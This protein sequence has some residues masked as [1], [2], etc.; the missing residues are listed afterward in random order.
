MAKRSGSN[1]RLEV[2]DRQ[3]TGPKEGGEGVYLRLLVDREGRYSFDLRYFG[4]NQE[5]GKRFS[6]GIGILLDEG[7]AIALEEALQAGKVALRARSA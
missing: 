1:Q 6:T 2:W 4:E 3:I 5:K 7:Q